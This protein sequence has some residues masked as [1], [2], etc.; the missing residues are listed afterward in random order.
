MSQGKIVSLSP[1]EMLERLVVFGNKRSDLFKK[2]FG[3]FYIAPFQDVIQ[4]LKTPFCPVKPQINIILTLFEGEMNLKI[5][6]E[7]VKLA[8]QSFA[9]IPTGQVFSATKLED[10]ESSRKGLI[11]GFSD[12]FLIEQFGSREL[13]GSFQF[14]NIW[15]NSVITPS[16]DS[17]GFIRNSLD[18]ILN[19]YRKDG[20]KYKSLIQAYLLAVLNEIGRGYVPMKRNKNKMAHE[21]SLR[22]QATL[23][24]NLT[25]MHSVKEYADHLNVSPNHLNKCL[26]LITDK[27]P[28]VW[29]QE[30]LVREAKVLLFQTDLTI[31]EISTELGFEDSSYF[32]RFFKK[33]EDMTPKEYR[34]STL[35]VS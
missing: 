25:V 12:D 10:K 17:I 18:R 7:E 32:S 9:I 14:L 33:N 21:L 20:L 31:Q 6:N 29:I 34:E 15:E 4:L 24:S 22:F 35:P 11:L 26:K 28:S 30:A 3:S 5:A 2:D 8:P 16:E 23:Q 13:T 27:S 1:E 19:T